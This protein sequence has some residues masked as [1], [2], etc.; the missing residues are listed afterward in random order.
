M[1]KITFRKVKDDSNIHSNVFLNGKHV[2]YIKI[3][4]V[5]ERGSRGT[6]K[7]YI[8]EHINGWR[9]VAPYSTLKE[10]KLKSEIN[11]NRIENK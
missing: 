8:F 6:K 9:S 3:I 5:M 7:R 2:G 1:D 4:N 11:V 10:A